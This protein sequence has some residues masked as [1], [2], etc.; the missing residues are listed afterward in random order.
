[1]N[2]PAPKSIAGP[3]P[4]NAAQL[5]VQ[6]SRQERSVVRLLALM[7]AMASL[8]YYASH[9]N[10]LLYG[11]AVAHL[12][13]ARRVVD[14]LNPGFRQLGS[15]WLPLPHILLIPFV[16]N[17][18]W[19][20]NGMAGAIP[21]VLT[22]VAGCVG[23]FRLARRWLEVGPA[24]LAVL[25]YATN[26]SLLY[27][28]TT[29]MTEPLY[30]AEM[31]WAV[32][33]LVELAAAVA[34]EKDGLAAH[35]LRYLSL[36]LAAAVFTRYDGWI[37]AAAAWFA[38]T[39]IVMRSS[40]RSALLGEWVLF[41][42]VVVVSP[43]LWLAYNAKQFHD[44]LDFLRGP[45]SA[46]AIELRTTPPGAGHYPGYHNLR[47]AWTYF[48]KAAQL[49]A[50]WPSCGKLLVGIAAVGSVAALMRHRS[51]WPTL[52]FWLP[53]PFYAY[54]VAYGSV[55]IFLPMWLPYAFYNT[56][57]GMELL[58]A[59]ALFV[60]FSVAALMLRVPRFQHW[61]P[62]VAGLLILV[63]SA[64]LLHARPLVLQEAMRNGRSR[65]A[66][67]HALAM[68]LA[69]IAR[70]EPILMYTSAHVG[71]LQQAR[72]PL[73]QTV[74]EGDYYQWNAALADPAAASPWVV[75]IDGDPVAAAIK[76]HSANLD[77][78]SVTC[79][80]DQGCARIYHSRLNTRGRP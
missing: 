35:G 20:Q 39:V 50:V 72:I 48:L 37:Y 29:A 52:L 79:S 25:F 53:L 62:P 4:L 44:P 5:L 70:G 61:L 1:M 64:A 36:V 74:N 49:N 9:G 42:V 15:V 40:R 41:S 19:W 18:K 11:D 63:N 28:A 13:I 76:L 77:L 2:K 47:I 80:S 34:A 68:K 14:S 67:E 43:L 21:S 32:V 12:H 7:L 31:I 58:P 73:K 78:L 6:Q 33:L 38:A 60:A 30:L 16:L 69:E 3:P 55:P 27:L 54:S 10:L 56:R 51:A 17:M 46:R 71:A 65:I 23:I 8:A 59:F 26:A 24:A 75:A 45:Y 57:Y 66:F 22:Y